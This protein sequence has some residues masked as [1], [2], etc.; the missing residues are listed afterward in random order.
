MLHEQPGLGLTRCI[1][2][3]MTAQAH[4]GDVATPLLQ[5][6]DRERGGQQDIA[7]QC[8]E[9]KPGSPRSAA[10]MQ[11]RKAVRIVERRMCHPVNQPCVLPSPLYRARV[12]TCRA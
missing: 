8:E 5:D 6:D 9:S 1:A 11:T 7:Q 3:P 2:R 10:S 12:G 4:A